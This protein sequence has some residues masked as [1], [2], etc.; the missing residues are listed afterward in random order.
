MGEF[1]TAGRA[2]VG[3]V[4]SLIG[5]AALA[6]ILSQQ[7]QTGSILTQGGTALS[8]VIQ[9]AVAPVSGGGL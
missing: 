2:I 4:A 9:A 7:A 3:I 8:S 5:L 1:S 6:V